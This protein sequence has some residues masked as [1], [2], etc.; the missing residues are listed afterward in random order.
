MNYRSQIQTIIDSLSQDKSVSAKWRNKAVARLEDAD[1][2]LLKSGIDNPPERT[3]DL[4]DMSSDDNLCIC[5]KDQNG[6]LIALR[7]SCPIHGQ[8]AASLL[9]AKTKTASSSAT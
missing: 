4:P 2:Y 9:A 3:S 7:R 6:K 8:E 5:R 1:L